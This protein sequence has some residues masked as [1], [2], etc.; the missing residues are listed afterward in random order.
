MKKAIDDLSKKITWRTGFFKSTIGTVAI[1]GGIG[2]MITYGSRPNDFDTSYP[3]FGALV[4]AIGIII[5]FAGDWYKIN[6]DQDLETMRIKRA[7]NLI[8]E[9][10]DEEKERLAEEVLQKANEKKRAIDID[11]AREMQRIRDGLC[12]DVNNIAD[13]KSKLKYCSTQEGNRQLE[14]V[15]Y[16]DSFKVETIIDI[17]MEKLKDRG[18]P[19]NPGTL[20]RY[21][22]DLYDV[23]LISER[24]LEECNERLDS[25]EF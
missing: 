19:I 18:Q 7:S 20:K 10:I 15:R 14:Y 3:I 9:K 8:D 25:I 22:T 24:K 6:K 2:L 21:C 4:V 5:Y 1:S 17:G 11:T 13:D 12:S 16:P 23:G